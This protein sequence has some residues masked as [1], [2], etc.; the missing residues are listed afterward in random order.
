[1]YYRITDQVA[2]PQSDKPKKLLCLQ[3]IAFDDDGRIELRLAYY[4]IGKKGKMRG[5][6]VWGQYAAFLP[7]KDFAGR[8]LSTRMRQPVLEFSE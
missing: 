6:W 5:R 7:A 3:R 4:I 1:M 8:S 2:Q